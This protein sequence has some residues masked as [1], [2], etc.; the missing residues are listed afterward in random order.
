MKARWLNR[1]P[2]RLSKN[3]A[4][5]LAQVEN[6]ESVLA[7]IEGAV[8]LYFALAPDAGEGRAETSTK[9]R[10]DLVRLAGALR[11]AREILECGGSARW[12]FLNAC[13]EHLE[14]ETL[15][16]FQ[17]LEAALFDGELA[18]LADSAA[19]SVTVRSGRPQDPEKQ[20]RL[21]LVSRVADA[22]KVL[23][24]KSGRGKKFHTLMKAIYE[25]AGIERTGTEKAIDPARDLRGTNP[26]EPHG[27]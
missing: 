20:L 3:R 11:T 2:V 23:G 27:H 16:R 10:D 6:D 15:A 17:Q 25:S 24:I 14:D 9:T 26:R 1:R 18:D 12:L 4:D 21:Q 13:G 19:V 22:V 8:T 7:K 5:L